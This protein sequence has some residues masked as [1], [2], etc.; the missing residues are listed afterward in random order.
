MTSSTKNT[1][2]LPITG[3]L[4]LGALEVWN[5]SGPKANF[6]VKQNFHLNKEIKGR[7]KLTE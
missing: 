6:F 2:T 5:S 7:D 1:M 4:L 3:L